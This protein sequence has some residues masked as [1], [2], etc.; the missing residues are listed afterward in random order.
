MISYLT[1]LPIYIAH[2][3]VISFLYLITWGYILRSKST[4]L[5]DDDQGLARF[6]D[7]FMQEKDKD[8]KVLKEWVRDSYEHEDDT[9]VKDKDGKPVFK[10]TKFK[11]RQFNPLVGFPECYTRWLRLLWGAQFSKIGTNQKGHPVYGYLQS[12]QKHHFLSFLIFYSSIVLT[13]LF[14]QKFF[15]PNLALLSTILFLVHP[16]CA[17]SVAW[18]SSFGYLFCLFSIMIMLN[19]AVYFGDTVLVRILVGVFTFF[20]NTGVLVG[21]GSFITFFQL[22]FPWLSVISFCVSILCLYKMGM[23]YVKGRVSAF[24]EQEMER[25]TK[26]SWRKSI[27]MVKT[28]WYYLKLVPFPKRLGLYHRY[29]YHYDEFVERIDKDF[30]L[31]FGAIILLGSVFIY[32]PFPVQFGLLWFFSYVAVFTNF[33]TAQQFV[34]DRYVFIP[35]LGF[36]IIVS[37]CL[38]DFLLIYSFIAGILIMKTWSYLPAFN[39]QISFYRD[40]LLQFNGFEV[41]AGNLG[42]AYANRQLN[43]MAFDTWHECIKENPDYDVPHYNIY[44]F[45]KTTGQLEEGRK[46][47]EKCV[48][49]KVCHFPKPWS[50]E[51]KSL[52]EV[53]VRK[54]VYDALMKRFNDLVSKNDF[55]Q[56]MVVKQEIEEFMRKEKEIVEGKKPGSQQKV[57]AFNVDQYLDKLNQISGV[58]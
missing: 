47:L 19:G 1:D 50:D 29:C 5:I 49:S 16:L 52:D 27:A 32:L 48:N 46:F 37:Y 15:N 22:G 26:M 54:K 10:K 7:V 6:D 8:G 13:Y 41:P 43:G 2:L 38:Q 34:V 4:F 56:A 3:S 18:I 11:N 23:R 35:T 28:I 44:N 51:L 53:L 40:N 45:L 20:A 14:L 21:V 24:K 12:P 17:Q 25:P 42:V 31:G 36:S 55:S 9:G 39:D 58:R 30:W 57:E 33:V